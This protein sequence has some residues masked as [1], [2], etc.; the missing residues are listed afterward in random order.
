MPAASK[1]MTSSGSVFA[2]TGVQARGLAEDEGV[3]L[4][5]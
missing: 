5:L 3:T 1:L 4:A 2:D